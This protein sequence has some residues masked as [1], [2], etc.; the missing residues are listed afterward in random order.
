[1]SATVDLDDDRSHHS[2]EGADDSWQESWYLTWYD[3]LRRAGGSYHVGLQRP[4][5][6]A[7]VWSWTTLEGRLVG[8]YQS[9]V[10][11]LPSDDL[12][13]MRIGG[14]HISTT[15]PLTAYRVDAGYGD[16]AARAV[17]DYEAFTQPFAFGLDGE[18]VEIGTSH[19]E[20][21]G[22]LTGTV[23]A[24]D[25]RVAV[26][27]W[28]FQDH[29][30]G[31]RDWTSLL[32]HRWICATFSEDL[33]LSVA[34]FVTRAGR[35]VS[36]YVYDGGFDAVADVSFGTRVADDGHSPEGCDARIW[37]TDGRGYHLTG[38]CDAGAV[39]SHDG[40]FFVSDGLTTFEMGG[41]LGTG[42]FEVSE[43]KTLA[44]WLR[45][46]LGLDDVGTDP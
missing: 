2:P 45:D 10:L 43:L 38:T 7:D 37:T 24:D 39:S 36:G 28:A 23:T 9:L 8:H 25:A 30:W 32:S 19:Y 40:G 41:R 44:P 42:M 14:M 11:P 13:D 16:G 22:R 31:P 18:G 17:V 46:E 12:S 27:G 3:P 34:A 4:R 21:F 26:S 20:S 6:R 29:S 15:R 35:K 33:F 1:M 5:H